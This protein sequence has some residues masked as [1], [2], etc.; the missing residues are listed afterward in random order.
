MNIQGQV[1]KSIIYV[2]VKNLAIPKNILAYLVV[3]C[4]NID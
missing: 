4:Y 3:F 1:N 2:I